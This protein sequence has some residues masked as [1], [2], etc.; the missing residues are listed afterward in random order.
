MPTL[1]WVYGPLTTCQLWGRIW[2]TQQHGCCGDYG[3]CFLFAQ[4]WPGQ[5]SCA[6]YI[7]GQ[8]CH[9]ALLCLLCLHPAVGRLVLPSCAPIFC[10]SNNKRLGVKLCAAQSCAVQ[11]KTCMPHRPMACWCCTMLRQDQ[12]FCFWLLCRWWGGGEGAVGSVGA[13][14]FSG[15]A[16]QQWTREPEHQSVGCIE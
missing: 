15:H 3:C 13:V 10:T 12:A 5:F 7:W 1:S 2:P 6:A 8:P 4:G 14:A 9:L 16:Q 11:A